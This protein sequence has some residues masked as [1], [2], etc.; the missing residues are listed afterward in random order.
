M[1]LEKNAPALKRVKNAIIK[2]ER[3]F[4]KNELFAI[5]KIR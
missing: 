2:E 5:K 3:V 4:F 1:A